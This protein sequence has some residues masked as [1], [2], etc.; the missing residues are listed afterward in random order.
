MPRG[1]DIENVP[2]N[3]NLDDDME[4]VGSRPPRRR[5]L[6]AAIAGCGVLEVGS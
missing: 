5:F 1:K 4:I 2:A 6:R 3:D